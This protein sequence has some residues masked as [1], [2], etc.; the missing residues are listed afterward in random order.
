[1]NK[2]LT[3]ILAQFIFTSV[4]A[5][6]AVPVGPDSVFIQKTESNE[7]KFMSYNVL[8]LFDT[9][10]DGDN[11]DWAFLPANYPNKKAHCDEMKPGHD[12]DLCSNLDWTPERLNL[13]LDQIA[14]VVRFQGDIP[15]VLVLVEIE[16]HN[17]I[18]P[19]AKKLGYDDYSITDSKTKRGT[20][21]AILF[22]TAKL[23]RLADESINAT[24]PKNEKT[25]DILRVDLQIKGT[26]SIISV[27]GNH[28]PSQMNPTENRIYAAKQLLNN[29]DQ[30]KN[31]Y[32]KFQQFVVSMGDYNVTDSD[33]PNPINDIVF[34]KGE[35]NHLLDGRTLANNRP[36]NPALKYMPEGTFYYSRDKVWDEFDRVILS[37]NLTSNLQ[38]QFLPD[39]FRIIFPEFMSI[40][41][42]ERSPLPGN[43]TGGKQ[44]RIPFEYNFFANT[45]TEAGYSDHLPVVF[46][47]RY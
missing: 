13:K 20:N 47:L 32:G 3:L 9:E 26:N 38:V 29:I 34:A 31:H 2:V 15:D 1:M 42:T 25:R 7:I 17:V 4:F 24:L 18:E 35:K 45:P 12:K 11:D 41:H 40:S 28:W 16:N 19:L 36:S 22:K 21:V 27:Y 43:G 5:S 6:T 46:K 33:S 8:N 37:P 39:S 23:I 14:S 10:K 30:M 44:I